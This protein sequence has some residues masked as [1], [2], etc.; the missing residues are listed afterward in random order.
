MQLFLENFWASAL[1]I[2]ETEII[3]RQ[4]LEEALQESQ[5]EIQ[6]KERQLEQAQQELQ[7]AKAQQ[8]IQS[9]K[10][11]SLKQQIAGF[12]QEINNPVSFIDGNLR[13]A[14]EYTQGL[15]HII[16]LYAKHY[17]QPASEIQSAIEDEE[18][19]FDF[20]IKDLPKILSTM[21]MATE[22]I[23]EINLSLRNLSRLNKAEMMA[24]NL[25]QGIERT[26]MIFHWRL[27]GH[28]QLYSLAGCLNAP[29][30]EII[31]EYGELPLVE[32]YPGLLDQAFMNLLSFIIDALQERVSSEMSQQTT[33]PSETATHYLPTITIRTGV[34]VDQTRALIQIAD[35]GS[36]RLPWPG[37]PSGAFPVRAACRTAARPPC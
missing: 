27:V 26:L 34:S 24:V 13:Y 7:R 36:C 19:D 3:E 2:L 18:L 5:E 30:I 21:Q 29:D 10:L 37:L 28:H 11:F 35:N 23:R 12:V 22:R 9:E 15:L 6:Q 25:H 32:C 4:Q 1:S 31:K 8:L 20:L 14:R 16:H 33:N 17:P